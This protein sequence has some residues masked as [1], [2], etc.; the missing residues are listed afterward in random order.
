MGRG[1]AARRLG[2][3]SLVFVPAKKRRGWGGGFGVWGLT[4]SVKR[5]TSVGPGGGG[6][7]ASWSQPAPFSKGVCM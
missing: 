5:S 4:P 7:I 1:K 3:A 2:R 6:G